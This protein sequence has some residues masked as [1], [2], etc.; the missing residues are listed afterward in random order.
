M[1]VPSRGAHIIFT[2]IPKTAGRTITEEFIRAFGDR[3]VRDNGF[4]PLRNKMKSYDIDRLVFIGGHVTL[5]QFEELLGEDPARHFCAATLREPLARAI[6]HYLFILRTDVPAMEHI[7][8]PFVGKSFEYFVDS[9]PDIMPD[10]LVGTQCKYLCG[11]PDAELALATIEQRYS[12]VADTTRFGEF[13]ARLRQESGNVIDPWSDAKAL[14]VA[15]VAKDLQDV[16]R[17]HRPPDMSTLAPA[18]V[19][20]KLER[21]AAADYEL[22]ESFNKRHGGYFCAAD[23]DG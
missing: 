22:L 8:A 3:A 11:E 19:V 23:D 18:R 14:N 9:S 16:D 15:P 10:L 1:P 20:R 12:L 5:P 7:R 13:Y 4:V 6:S 17:G 2:H 21:V